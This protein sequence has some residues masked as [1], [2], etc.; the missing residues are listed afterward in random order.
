MYSCAGGGGECCQIDDE[1]AYLT[2]KVVLV[3]VPVISVRII[4]IR[5]D[6][7]NALE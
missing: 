4:H 3:G 2:E 5:V 1:I 7:C 6:D